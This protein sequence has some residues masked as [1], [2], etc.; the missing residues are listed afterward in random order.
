[1]PLTLY[2]FRDIDLMLKLDEIGN[3]EGWATSQEI[4]EAIGVGDEAR[5]V[6][7]RASWMRRYGMFDFD[8]NTR[9]WRLS[10]GGQRVTRA[11][12]RAAASKQIETVP[13]E[14]LVEVMAHVTSRYRHG[15]PMTATMLRREFLYGT[16]NR[17]NGR[18]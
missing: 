12:L 16:S 18:R 3:D 9:M 13:D 8:E 4:A 10:A 2:D 1:M 5:F 15:D 14:S 11:K 6:S 17:W 7:T